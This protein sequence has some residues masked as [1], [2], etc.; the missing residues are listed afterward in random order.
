MPFPV[1]A[2]IGAMALNT[3]A[4]IGT[5]VLNNLQQRS[6]TREQQNWQEAMYNRY[7][8]PAALMR[9]Y[10]AAGLN[11]FL[12]MDGNL[13]S[14]MSASPVAN[15]NGT[16]DLGSPGSDI[17]QGMRT[18]ADMSLLEQQV[19]SEKMKQ[20]KQAVDGIIAAVPLGDSGQKIIDAYLPAF[21]N[22]GLS[23]TL[24]YDLTTQLK[25]NYAASSRRS[26]IL[27]SLSEDFG[28][29]EVQTNIMRTEREIDNAVADLAVKSHTIKNIDASTRELASR[30]NSNNAQAG[31]YNASANK[32]GQLLAYEVAQYKLALG[33][34]GM[35]FLTHQ[36]FFNNDEMYRNWLNSSIGKYARFGSRMLDNDNNPIFKFADHL[37]DYIPAAKMSKGVAGAVRGALN[38]EPV[39]PPSIASPY[40]MPSM[41]YGSPY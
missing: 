9:Q 26:N 28:A 22:L 2:A 37:M 21:R 39:P 32:I 14:G 1:A 24:A 41:S 12:A 13:G 17:M 35:N 36:S 6:L 25:N 4:N 16:Y 19:D 18:S 23:D 38:N 30:V 7:S 3:G 10:K 33:E 5:S 29:Q 40:G 27:A 20:F 8:S 11:P 15:V 34:A 31:F